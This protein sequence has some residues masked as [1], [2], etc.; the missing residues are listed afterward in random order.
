MARVNQLQKIK[1]NNMTHTNKTKK[2]TKKQ[3]CLTD[4]ELN[5]IRKNDPIQ[6]SVLFNEY[7]RKNNNF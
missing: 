7:K 2:V 3:F 1:P 5:K 4:K 6:F